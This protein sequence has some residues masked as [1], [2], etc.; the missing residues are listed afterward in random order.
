MFEVAVSSSTNNISIITHD[1]EAL[2]GYGCIEVEM[3]FD[4]LSACD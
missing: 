1:E 2:V 3:S 4:E